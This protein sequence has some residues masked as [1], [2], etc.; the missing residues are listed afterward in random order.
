MVRRF[1]FMKVII[2]GSINEC[3]DHSDSGHLCK[4]V[5]ELKKKNDKK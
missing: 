2:Y 4:L 1:H 5:C 3:F